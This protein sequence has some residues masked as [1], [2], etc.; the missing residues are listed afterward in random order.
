MDLK[1]YDSLISV[2]ALASEN[3]QDWCVIDCRFNIRD[4]PWGEQAYESG[5]IPGAIY[6]HL[7]RDL[8]GE[9][10]PGVTGR[11]PL[12]PKEK[13]LERIESWGIT[14]N[15]QVI[16]YDQGPGMFAARLWWLLRWIGHES[17]AVLNGGLAACIEQGASV[18][19]QIPV[20]Q[21][22]NYVPSWQDHILKDA[23]FVEANLESGSFCLIDVRDPE[24]YAGIIEPIDPVAGHI[25][26]AVNKPFKANLN[27]SNQWRTQSEIAADFQSV[28][29][30]HSA[31]KTIMYCGS[32]V[33]ACHKILSYYHAGLGMP[34]LYAGSWSD[35]ITDPSRA[36]A[37][38]QISES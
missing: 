26:G 21:R 30:T 8:S 18:T 31:D 11:H 36:I 28:T 1:R 32:G 23:A 2:E 22:S 13:L 35:W 6:A 37:P 16:A 9:I 12:P 33:T 17:V 25:P 7:D 10:I 3:R 29:N 5:H 27:E 24:R 20:T 34:L 38:S 19:S 14:P 4:T 15:T